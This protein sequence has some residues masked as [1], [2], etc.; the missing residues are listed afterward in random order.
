MG[1]THP[2]RTLTPTS[3]STRAAT[4]TLT[5]TIP[6]AIKLTATADARVKQTSP[7]TNYGKATTLQADGDAGAAV[8]SFIRFTTSGISGP[9][10]I[11]RGRKSTGNQIG[12]A[13]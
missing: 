8:A 11:S 3:T 7:T 4:L 6:G 12:W 2:A 9:I 1:D 13:L 10:P 5:A